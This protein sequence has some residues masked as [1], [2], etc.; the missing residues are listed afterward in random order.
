LAP[1]RYWALGQVTPNGEAQSEMKL[2]SPDEAEA[3]DRL[4]HAAEAGNVLV[5]L[6]PCQNMSGYQLPVSLVAPKN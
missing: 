1:G 6:K 5:E 3:R 2:R 4:R